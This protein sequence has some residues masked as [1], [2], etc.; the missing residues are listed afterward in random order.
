MKL[1][2]HTL[3]A[4]RR[5]AGRVPR[6]VED[7]HD[8]QRSFVEDP[9][10]YKAALCARRAGKSYGVAAWLLAGAHQHPGQRSVYI[11]LSRSK[12]YEIIGS[13]L[14][15]YS[16]KY[17]LGI[18]IR[19]VEGSLNVCLPNGHRIWL[20]GCSDKSEIEKFRG[21]ALTRAVV[22]EAQAFGDYL[23]SLVDDAL[24]PALLD[25][26]GDLAL[27]GT[28]GPV[29]A[30]YF[31]DVTEGRTP[32]VA[33]WP[34]HRWTA[35]DNSFI[36]HAA[37]ELEDI[38]VRNG[39]T[40]D[41]PT[42]KRESLGLWVNDAN[43][44]IYPLEPN[45]NS[46]STLPEG[47]YSYAL[48]VDIGFTRCS[49]FVVMALRRPQQELYCLE[50]TKVPGLLPQDLVTHVKGI[51]DR[52]KAEGISL[53]VIVDEGGLGVG[54]AETMRFHGLGAI[55]AEKQGKR[56]AQ[57]W[58]RGTVIARRCKFNWTQTQPLI[59]ECA[60]LAFGEDQEEDE[61]FE[62]D[63]CDA[64]LYASRFLCPSMGKEPEPPPPAYGT[65]QYWRQQ[66]AAQKAKA[67]QA[68][69]KKRR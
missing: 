7:C 20:A 18:Q 40:V 43:Q 3:E 53:P 33:P 47:R 21:E 57:E 6:F 15:F 62:R 63:A 19:G 4:L 14:K 36:P 16:H 32:G 51:Q 67:A 27:I 12:A 56:N 64:F 65:Q 55:A 30:G 48:G 5:A 44:I 41:H 50:A 54:Y 2:V 11:T 69:T 35:L 45:E 39:W 49:A 37:Q 60:T 8:R 13:A 9:S 25:A 58:L 22:D 23:K 42:Y 29:C 61:R 1:P 34:T 66:M 10:R 52:Y 17:D 26:R 38:R 24:T 31:Y 59:R 28:P 46:Y 68:G